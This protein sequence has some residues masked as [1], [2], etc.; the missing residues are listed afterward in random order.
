MYRNNANQ[1][2]LKQKK[3]ARIVAT[4]K[5]ANVPRKLNELLLIFNWVMEWREI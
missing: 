5:G 2:P 4:I 1:N 3:C